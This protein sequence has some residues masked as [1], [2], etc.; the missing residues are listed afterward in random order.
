MEENPVSGLTSVVSHAP[1]E[2]LVR[3]T[4]GD[5]TNDEKEVS[6]SVKA[7]ILAVAA[8]A[9]FSK[10][11]NDPQRIQEEWPYQIEDVLFNSVLVRNNQLLVEL[12]AEAKIDLPEELRANM[13][14]TASG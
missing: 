10:L 6:L 9:P 5:K 1:I 8:I 13:L 3:L 4:R 14:R 7:G 2:S 11:R 12:A